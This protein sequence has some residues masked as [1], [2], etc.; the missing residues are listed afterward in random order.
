MLLGPL[1]VTAVLT[2]IY[3]LSVL[4][5][6]AMLVPAN[7]LV[8][9]GRGTRYEWADGVNMPARRLRLRLLLR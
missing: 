3:E 1:G 7:L 6:Y 5:L 8:C 2:K 4:I 9:L